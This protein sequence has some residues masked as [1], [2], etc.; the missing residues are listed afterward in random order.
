MTS[1]FDEAERAISK[2]DDLE[3]V[4]RIESR[5]WD[6]CILCASDPQFPNEIR[7]RIL[8]AHDTAV[9]SGENSKGFETWRIAKYSPMVTSLHSIFHDLARMRHET[10]FGLL[11][12]SP[13]QI[14]LNMREWQA[15][16]ES[17]QKRQH[18][19]P[20]AECPFGKT[21]KVKTLG[22]GDPD[23]YIGQIYGPFWFPC[24]LDGNYDDKQSDPAEVTQCAGAAIF[25]ANL[26][27]DA[28]MPPALLK[29]EKDEGRSFTSAEEFVKHH[30]GEDKKF[31]PEKLMEL[32]NKE[33]R[34]MNAR[35][36]VLAREAQKD[37]DVD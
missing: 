34:D 9:F 16:C 31:P 14:L 20:C 11:L 25:R 24:H 30:T 4:I 8:Q 3:E 19:K 23:T 13:S 7:Q 12:D 28:K 6:D 32:L 15:K 2:T 27:L 33:L 1:Y 17:V 5:V 10:R 26:E 29:A 36:T 18:R 22:G 21:A 37:G 35:M